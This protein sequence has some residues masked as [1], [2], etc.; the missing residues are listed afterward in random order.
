MRKTLTSILGVLLVILG[1]IQLLPLLGISVV[2]GSIDFNRW[3]PVAFLMIGMIEFFAANHSGW[4]WGVFSI[5]F[6]LIMMRGM[7]NLPLL[8]M[9]RLEELFMPVF[10]LAYGIKTLTEK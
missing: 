9:L 2:I 5:L 4:F 1:L 6:G 7:F 10:A 3:F 8:D